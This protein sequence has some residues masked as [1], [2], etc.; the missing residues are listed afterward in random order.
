ME[1]ETHP[2][3]GPLAASRLD[4]VRTV[5]NIAT[6]VCAFVIMVVVL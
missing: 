4:I 1:A 6:A 3:V 2:T 5:S